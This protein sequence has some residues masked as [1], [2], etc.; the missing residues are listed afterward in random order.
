M[1]RAVTEMRG[2]SFLSLRAY[3]K[4]GNTA[5]RRRADACVSASRRI[6]TSTMCSESGG[7]AVW[8]TNTSCSRTFSSILT[9]RFSFEKRFVVVAPGVMPRHLQISCASPGWEDPEKILSPSTAQMVVREG[10]RRASKMASVQSVQC[11][12]EQG[13]EGGEHRA[14]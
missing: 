14:A 12:R 6:S 13:D 8:T 7:A 1:R 2:S 4:Y 9:L 10:Q 5:V 3:G 11:R